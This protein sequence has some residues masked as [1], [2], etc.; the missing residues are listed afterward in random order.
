MPMQSLLL[1]GKQQ[2]N[3]YFSSLER[4]QELNLKQTC[5]HQV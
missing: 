3:H 4:I 5:T 2:I 1:W